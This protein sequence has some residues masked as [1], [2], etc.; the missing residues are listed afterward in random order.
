MVKDL[1]HCSE[2]YVQMQVAC[3]NRLFNSN[4]LIGKVE[5]KGTEFNV[6]LSN[7]IK[8]HYPHKFAGTG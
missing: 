7:I 2:I 8:D 3:G 6:V 5:N 1:C 4:N